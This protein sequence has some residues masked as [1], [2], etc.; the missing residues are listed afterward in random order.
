MLT[1][2]RTSSLTQH[3]AVRLP[4]LVLLLLGCVLGLAPLPGI[5]GPAVPPHR[6]VAAKPRPI[7]LPARPA[8]W[9]AGQI[10]VQLAPDQRLR[11]DA[12][13]AIQAGGAALRPVLAAWGLD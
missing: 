12:A 11:L 2:Y 9:Q 10:L 8:D 4:A 1:T 3:P 13:G 7:P 5:A 6:R